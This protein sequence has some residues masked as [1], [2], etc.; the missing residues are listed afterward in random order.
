MKE[1]VINN[2]K[3]YSNDLKEK[4]KNYLLISKDTKSEK[5]PFYVSINHQLI[6][7]RIDRAG[8]F[9]AITNDS[10][11]PLQTL[12]TI[13][14][15]DCVEK[16][17]KRMKDGLGL[18]T[19]LVH[20]NATYNGKMFVVFLA[21]NLIETFRW[22]EKSYFE[23]NPSSTTYIVLGELNKII[24]TFKEGTITQKYALTAKQKNYLQI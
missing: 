3:K 24:F 13:R 10:L 8:F 1:Y 17:F 22:F 5:R 4:Y 16:V 21:L 7:K 12:T 6:Q 19:P 18:N 20:N 11:T 14:K 9:V 15:R 23:K 2:Y